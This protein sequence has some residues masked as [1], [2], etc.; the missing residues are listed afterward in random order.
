MEGTAQQADQMFDF[1][2]WRQ[3]LRGEANRLH[4]DGF[5]SSWKLN[6]SYLRAASVEVSGRGLLGSFR[7]Y[8]NGMVDYEVARDDSGDFIANEAMIRV[9]NENFPSVFGDFRKALGLQP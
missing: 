9:T 3:W 7:Q 2:N 1:E 5:N 6:N 8:E 4:S